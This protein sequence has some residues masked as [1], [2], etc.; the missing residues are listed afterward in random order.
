MAESISPLSQPSPT[1]G[2]SPGA[3]HENVPVLARH[4]RAA[5]AAFSEQLEQL[6]ADSTLSADGDYLERMAQGVANIQ[7]LIQAVPQK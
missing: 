3:A 5:A 6:M 2:T 7:Q 4:V 1:S